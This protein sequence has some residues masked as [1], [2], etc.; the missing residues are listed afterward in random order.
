MNRA[1]PTALRG[2]TLI[3]MIGVL[4]IIST[5]AAVLVP[6]VVK[7]VDEAVMEAE[8]KNLTTLAGALETYTTSIKRIPNAAGWVA[9]LAGVTSMS[10]TKVNLNERGFRR[11]YY[12]DP[13]FFTNTAT[14]FAGYTQTN[15]R[16]TAPVSPRIMIVSDLTR[17]APAAPTTAAAFNAIWNQTAGATVLEGARVR[18]QRIHL[19][20][21]FLPVLLTNQFNSAVGYNI[22]TRGTVSLPAASAGGGTGVT[23]YLLKGSKV[24][25]RKPPFPSGALERA[26]LVTAARELSYVSSGG[27]TPVW[28]WSAP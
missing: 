16:T 21:W 18:V 11:G 17:N 14:A 3:E 13:R 22:E 2:F 4:A 1:R 6:N 12:V 9:A 8:G 23:R 10:T 26:V 28:S 25:L 19:G 7:T 20:S 5:L 27:A 24:S 15:G